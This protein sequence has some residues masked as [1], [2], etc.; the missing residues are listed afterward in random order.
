MEPRIIQG[1]SQKLI[2]SPQIQQYL[3]MLGL[4]LAELSQAVESELAENPLLEESDTEK[5]GEEL[6][7]AVD[8]SP[9]SKENETEELKV[10]ESFGQFDKMDESFREGWNYQDTSLA[11]PQDL[12]RRKNF[13]E[14]LLTSPEALSDFLLWQIRFL[15]LSD[16]GRKIAE[17]II[18][19]IDENGYLKCTV[20]EIATA[21]SVDIGDVE[22]ILSQIQQLEPPGI[23]ARNLQE[24]L[25]LQLKKKTSVPAADLGLEIVTHHLDSLKKRDWPH[26]AKVLGADIATV[27]KAADLIARLEPR[28]GRSFYSEEPTVITPDATVSF[29]DVD[30]GKL[31][32]EIHDEI[33]PQ[34]RINPY[35]RRMLRQK[36]L[37]PKTKE[38][39]QQKMTAALNFIKS[40]TLRKSTLRQVT[41]ELVKVQGEFFEKGFS[42][43]HPL[44]LK[45]VARAIGIHESTVSRALHGKYISTPQGTIPFKSFFS[46]KMQTTTGV[47]ESQK[48]IMEKI[49]SLV[50]SEDPAHPLSDQDI[51][52][53]LQQEGIVIARRT[54]AKYRDLLKILPSHLRRR[55]SLGI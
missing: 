45:D 14:S 2:L 35:Y 44:R 18:G 34:L 20:E 40:L 55:R 10:G 23:G 7:P 5:K 37:D 12:Q 15:D 6:P 49:R 16:E 19:N 29:D 30:E 38:F 27:Q 9:R 47:D 28:P 21:C 41:E 32:I 39:L 51:L 52:G 26:L 13:E 54:V 1:Q 11:D 46:T 50:D 53:R 36:D 24:A 42:H 17:E 8:G 22:T 25:I 3:K 48:S 43:L 4:P 33:I 31:K